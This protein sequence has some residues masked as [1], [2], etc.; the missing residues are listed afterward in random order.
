M[1]RNQVYLFAQRNLSRALKAQG[2]GDD[3]FAHM[4][5][6]KIF[7]IHLPNGGLGSPQC[8]DLEAHLPYPASPEPKGRV[9]M[10]RRM[11]SAEMGDQ[12]CNP[13]DFHSQGFV[14]FQDSSE[15]N[16]ETLFSKHHSLSDLRDMFRTILEPVIQELIQAQ[17]SCCGPTCGGCHCFK[18][19]KASKTSSFRKT[20]HECV[21][22]KTRLDALHGIQSARVC[23]TRKC[24]TSYPP[25]GTA[26]PMDELCPQVHS[27]ESASE[28]PWLLGPILP[29][30]T[31]PESRTRSKCSKA[32]L[33][34]T[35]AEPEFSGSEGGSAIKIRLRGTISQ[36]QQRCSKAPNLS[37]DCPQSGWYFGREQHRKSDTAEDS[38][39]GTTPTIPT[40]LKDQIA[41][42]SSPNHRHNAE[43]LDA[44]RTDVVFEKEESDSSESSSGS[45]ISR[46]ANAAKYRRAM[47]QQE[48]VEGLDGC[49]RSMTGPLC[50]ER[51]STCSRR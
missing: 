19:Q 23:D 42:S 44:P 24:G 33:K 50:K 6:I 1:M 9:T 31:S 41:L 32:E 4:A 30:S 8:N 10:A 13:V 34:Q 3:G 49:T 36:K 29:D 26:E 18:A 35:R 17:N 45:A 37:I 27:T 51:W 11:S 48:S 39:E 40:Y 38:M 2:T 21:S 5:A 47:R 15:P 16:P 20:R 25:V 14:S 46:L 43:Q 22:M 7:S 28:V 12:H